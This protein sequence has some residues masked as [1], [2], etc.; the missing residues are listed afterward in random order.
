MNVLMHVH[1]LTKILE[2]MKNQCATHME[3]HRVHMY[4]H[5]YAKRVE[6]FGESDGHIYIHVVMHV[7]ILS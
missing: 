4:V 7:H 2:W 1:I 6:Q 3:Q 5:N